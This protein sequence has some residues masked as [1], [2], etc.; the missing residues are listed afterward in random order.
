MN[1]LDWFLV[2]L[3]LAYA[4]SGYW[5]GFIAGAFATA[6][7]AARRPA[8][9][10]AGPAAARRRGPR[11]CGSPWPRCS[12]C[13]SARPSARRSCSTPAREIRVRI[14]WQPVRALDAVG[15][16][17]L[18]MA[19]VLVVAWALGVAVS[20][21]RLPWASSEVRSSAV[22]D[23]VERRDAGERRR[24][25]ELLQRRGRV[26]LLPALPRAVR[27]RADHRRRPAAGTRRPRPRRASAPRRA[28]S[29]S[30]ARTPAAGASR[31]AASSTRPDRVMTNAHV[32]AGVDKPAVL[33]GE[34]AVRRRP[35]STTTPTS[36]SRCSPS[37]APAGP[38]CASTRRAGRTRPA[39]CSATPQDGPYDVQAARIRGRAAAAQ[40]RHLRRRHRRAR[41]VLDA[42][43]GPARATPAAR[44]SRGRRRARGDLRGV[45]HRQ[46]H[47]LRP[48][49]RP[50]RRGRR[51]GPDPLHRRR[52]RRLRR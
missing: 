27:A 34:D 28:S 21:A 33:V 29:R 50:G 39:R 41:G 1:V 32:V 46:R 48:D 6:R 44:W 51:A 45:G 43:A 49:R 11:R 12:W 40:P 19:A 8:R 15:G 30:A 25:A 16:A 26:E 35:S 31:A 22:L 14:T 17:A 42:R 7:P 5:Q 47:R 52:H 13:W 2:V 38:S 23:R 4:V 20:G 10:L 18:S 9:R 24:G 36:T 37:T 3:V